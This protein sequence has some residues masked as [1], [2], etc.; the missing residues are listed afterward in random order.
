MGFPVP[1][2]AFEQSIDLNRQVVTNLAATFFMRVEGD[3]QHSI[4]EAFLGLQG[5]THQDL[6]AYGDI[7]RTTVHQWTGIPASVGM[8]KTTHWDELPTVRVWRPG[9]SPH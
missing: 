5:F 4:D 3:L 2:D 7:I 9:Q 1:G 8:A 6:T